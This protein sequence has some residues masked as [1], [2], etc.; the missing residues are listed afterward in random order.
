MKITRKRIIFTYDPMDMPLSLQIGF[1]FVR[2]AV[3]SVILP[4][5]SDFEPLCET[6]APGYLKLVTVPSLFP[7][8]LISFWVSLALDR[9]Q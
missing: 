5:T 2:A 6:T 4:R 9:L 7:L 3:T 1:C 8:T